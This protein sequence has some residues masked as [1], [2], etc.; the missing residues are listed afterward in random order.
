MVG[1]GSAAP[2]VMKAALTVSEGHGCQATSLAV[3]YLVNLL[4]VFFLDL[5]NL[6][7]TG[8]RFMFFATPV[9]WT[10][11][12][13][14]DFRVLLEHYNPA[15]YYLKMSRQAFGIEPMWAPSWA[16]GLGITLPVCLAG[17]IAYQRSHRL[18]RNIK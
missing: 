14:N 4:T 9:F 10:S 7:K 17:L 8:I 13:S 3:S 18:V 15:S 1:T 5:A 6:V 11:S 2:L 16:A 12:N